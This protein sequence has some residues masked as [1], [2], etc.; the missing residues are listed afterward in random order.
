MAHRFTNRVRT[1]ERRRNDRLPAVVEGSDEWWLSVAHHWRSAMWYC[2]HRALEDD[3]CGPG[4]MFMLTCR[5]VAREER[6]VPLAQAMD[7]IGPVHPALRDSA[8]LSDA[9]FLRLLIEWLRHKNRGGPWLPE[10]TAKGFPPKQLWEKYWPEIWEAWG[11][12]KPP[13]VWRASRPPSV[14]VW[15][16]DDERAGVNVCNSRH[17]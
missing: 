14:P 8:P 1:L 17:D 11:E 10:F 3:G 9:L 2:W 6:W 16:P 7:Y 4:D 5:H 12:G 15:T 13:S